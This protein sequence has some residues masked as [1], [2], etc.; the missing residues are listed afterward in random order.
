METQRYCRR[1]RSQ[2]GGGE[3]V[4]QKS[5]D[6]GS[7]SLAASTSSRQ[8]SATESRTDGAVA[9]LAGA[10]SGSL[11]FSRAGLDYSA[12]GGDDPAAVRRPLSSCPWQSPPSPHQAESA[13]AHPEGDPTR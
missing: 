1:T 3:S 4:V 13:K 10:G 12:G 5:E 9:D 2:R 7:R 8:A 11:R 6:T